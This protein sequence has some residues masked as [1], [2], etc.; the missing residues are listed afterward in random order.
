MTALG[1]TAFA[2]VVWGALALVGLV[3]AYELYAVYSEFRAASATDD[4]DR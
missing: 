2:V 1:P 4:G 3:F